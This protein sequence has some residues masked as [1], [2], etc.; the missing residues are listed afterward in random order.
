MSLNGHCVYLILY[1]WLISGVPKNCRRTVEVIKL[2]RS[3]SGYKLRIEALIEL[4]GKSK[5][6]PKSYFFKNQVHELRKEAIPI[7]W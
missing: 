1:L 6:A 3:F 5:S 4:T 2:I 7:L